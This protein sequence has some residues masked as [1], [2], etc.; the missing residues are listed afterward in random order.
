MHLTETASLL[1]EIR[2]K[3]SYHQSTLSTSNAKRIYLN[4]LTKFRASI[5]RLDFISAL[6]QL[7]KPIKDSP[8]FMTESDEI[9]IT[10]AE[11]NKLSKDLS[12]LRN[13]ISAIIL[14][15]HTEDVEEIDSIRIKLPPFHTFEELQKLSGELKLAVEV[16]LYNSHIGAKVDIKR[17]ETG[18][19][20]F[21]IGLGIRA[22]GQM[23]AD[24]AHLALNVR[25]KKIEGDKHIEYLKQNK[26]ATDML[27]TLSEF[28][29]T[30]VKNYL[31]EQAEQIQNKYFDTKKTKDALNIIKT[32]AETFGNLYEKGMIVQS[33]MPSAVDNEVPPIKFPSIDEI[34][35][36][37]ESIKQISS[38]KNGDQESA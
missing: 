6:K 14:L 35:L 13:A 5:E 22:A 9:T 20:W 28:T 3:L 4:E 16:P 33:A 15:A 10:D 8:I 24:L 32:A 11:A 38:S 2:P 17:A 31:D 18:S 23:L 29:K 37:K 7:L 26:A 19:I 27:N 34:K 25:M 12:S 1:E 21:L 30:T 36:L